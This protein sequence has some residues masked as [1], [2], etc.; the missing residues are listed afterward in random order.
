MSADHLLRSLMMRISKNLVLILLVAF[1]AAGTVFGLENYTVQK[2]SGKVEREK[3]G[4]WETV[5]TG[6]IVTG[7]TVLR[8]AIGASVTLVSGG[9]TN[10]IGPAKNGAVAV[11]IKGK[12]QIGGQVSKTDTDESERTT[13][14]VGTAS[15]RA[16][17][18]AGELPVDEE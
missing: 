5:K 15:A 7:E 9:T 18:A 6:D 13:G 3:N 16:G 12:I 4:A 2:V 17:D 14:R 11:L 1:A 10:V 8:T